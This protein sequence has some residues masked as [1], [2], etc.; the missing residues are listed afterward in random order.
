MSAFLTKYK[1]SLGGIFKILVI[2][3]LLI[4]VFLTTYRRSEVKKEPSFDDKATEILLD[5]YN[6]YLQ[7]ERVDKNAVPP[8]AARNLAQISLG[9]YE[10]L[11]EHQHLFDESSP[12]AL[13]LLNHAFYLSMNTMY[14]RKSIGSAASWIN[15][16]YQSTNRKLHTKAY[17]ND[18]YVMHILDETEGR[19]RR[20]TLDSD[21]MPLLPGYKPESKF[22]YSNHT[23]MLPAWG[24]NKT[25]VYDKRSF[26][27]EPPYI[28]AA[29]FEKALYDDALS[30]YV[31]SK[32]L[33]Y[34]DKWIG[35]FWSDETI[36]LTFTPIGRWVSIANQTLASEPL[37]ILQAV[38]MYRD[39]GVALYDATIVGWNFKYQYNLMRPEQFIRQNI[40]STWQPRYR[41]N[42]PSY[43]SAHSV[44]AGTAGTVL[45]HYFKKDIKRVD[46]SHQ[47]RLEFYSEKRV[48][49][50]FEDMY[51]ECAYSRFLVGVHYLTD[52][53]AG[54]NLGIAVANYVIKNGD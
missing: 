44:I 15:S 36:G 54:L 34:E 7:L 9:V 31:Q 48:Y 23:G 41:P 13:R 38:R 21:T 22:I 25:I 2:V 45:E 49:D 52:C 5:W 43:P 10:V 32:K 12:Q 46:D 6:L 39:L 35:D 1:N 19:F 18:Q 26:L 37:P 29:N 3:G 16:L 53:E 8:Y 11:Q 27:L 28:R 30:V 42:F 17:Y 47:K 20:D 24:K 4:S 14:D 40:D 50:N 51:K 33:S